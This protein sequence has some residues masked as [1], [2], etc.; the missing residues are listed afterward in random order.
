MSR[1]IFRVG[2][3]I[4]IACVWCMLVFLNSCAPVKPY[5]YESVWEAVYG[6]FP[7]YA[8]DIENLNLEDN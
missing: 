2:S 7:P 5:S 6:D 3:A 4:L 1:S 8:E